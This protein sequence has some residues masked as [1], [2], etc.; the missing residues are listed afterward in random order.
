M[1]A[2][3]PLPVPQPPGG[4]PRLVVTGFMGTG[5]TS[6]G[7]AAAASLGLPFFDLDEAVER[8]TGMSVGEVFAR[9]GE[10]SFRAIE[11]RVLARA[12]R[13]S[14]AVVATGGG[15]V[16][17]G[18]SFGALS[19]GSV[20]A[21]LTCD[22]EE[23]VRRVR[24]AGTRPLLEPDLPGRVRT[25]TREREPA[26]A[27]AGEALDTS[28]RS[29][30]DVGRVLADRYRAVPVPDPLP[31]PVEGV[32]TAYR[33]LVGRG[34]LDRAGP[35]LLEALPGARSALVACDPA[36]ASGPGGRVASALAEAGL[37]VTGPVTL[38][39]GE[40]AKTFEVLGDLWS[41][42]ATAGFG[43]A[44]AVVAVG[45]G[46]VLDAAG[47]A[48]AT[49]ARGI[50]L[51]NVPTT[52]LAMVD[53]GLGGKVAV[54]HAGRKNAV[55]AFHDPSL[56]LV[57]PD[58]LASL[59]PQHLRAG[60]AEAVKVLVL[61]SPL[62]LA[63]L[64]GGPPEG[65]TVDWTIEQAV[66]IKAGYVSADPRDRLLRHALNLGHTFAHGLESATGYGLAHG[67]AVAI[68]LVAAARL[69][70]RR[71]VTVP[72]LEG[73]LRDLLRALGL[74]VVPPD[75]VD[76]ARVLSAMAGDK[77]RRGGRAVFVV[78]AEDGAELLEGVPDEE[79]AA[80]L[81]PEEPA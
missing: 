77:K 24:A 70:S 20:V 50:A 18:E 10:A 61:A 30:Q 57:D 79:A 37:E 36:V 2:R 75:G 73:R 40:G 26:Y 8:E 1:I 76:R 38:P 51:V 71:G 13:L 64:E 34:V 42:L 28:G 48:A 54:D 65:R 67:D 15:A 11:R 6:A 52:L 35:V 45:G 12:A 27:A 3:T 4:R 68:G 41:R 58:V 39:E 63:A 17:D 9:R 21:V 78:P 31:V 43:R 44:D 69:G 29:V 23:I 14:G 53:A 16:L 19:A 5:K 32:E 59:R 55:G 25:L 74:P 47:F 7:R 56:V 33:V 62:G 81:W 80:A 66:R 60:L 46:G 49:F 22:E 72:A